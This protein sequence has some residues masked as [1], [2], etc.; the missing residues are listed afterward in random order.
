[1]KK[2]WMK[3]G[4]AMEQSISFSLKD[5]DQTTGNLEWSQV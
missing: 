5:E 1:M 4:E 3:S 2:G